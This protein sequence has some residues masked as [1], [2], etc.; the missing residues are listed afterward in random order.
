MKTLAANV[1]I[2][3]MLLLVLI[4]MACNDDPIAPNN[5][6][7]KPTIESPPNGGTG[8]SINPILRWK[9][10]DPDGDNLSYDVYFGTS[11]APPLQ[12]S[13]QSDTSYTP[14]TLEYGTEYNW[15]IVAKDDEGGST[16]SNI[17][18][19]TTI[20]PTGPTARFTADTTIAEDSLRV[21]F[22][23]QSIA[24]TSAIISWNWDFGDDNSSSL[25]NPSHLYNTIGAF[26]VSLTVNTA[27]GSDIETKSDYIVVNQQTGPEPDAPILY[28]PPDETTIQDQ[29]PT[30]VWSEPEYADG[31]H[32]KVDNDSLFYSAEINDTNLS[33]TTYTPSTGLDY[34]TYYWIVRAKNIENVWGDWSDTCSFTINEPPD[35]GEVIGYVYES[36]NGSIYN[37]LVKLY[38]SGGYTGKSDYTN[39]SGYFD[40]N[41][42]DPGSYY[43]MV[44]KSGYEPK[45]DPSS[46]Y[47]TV[48]PGETENRGTIYLTPEPDPPEC[49][50]S[51]TSLNF[52]NVNIDS[53]GDL[54]FTITNTGGG[55]LS[56]DPNETCSHYSIVSGGEPY[57]LGGGQSHDVTVRFSPTSSGTKTCTIETGNPI[58]SDVSCTGVSLDS[59][60][61]DFVF[62]TGG[63]FD[64]SG[65]YPNINEFEITISRVE[66]DDPAWSNCYTPGDTVHARFNPWLTFDSWLEI[67]RE[68]FSGIWVYSSTDY[69]WFTYT[70]DFKQ[71]G[72]HLT[73]MFGQDCESFYDGNTF[74]DDYTHIFNPSACGSGNYYHVELHVDSSNDEV[75][76][77]Q[78]HI[79]FQGW[80]ANY[81]SISYQ[82][83]INIINEE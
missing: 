37:A 10:S 66:L 17:W 13:S 44:S 3:L 4:L 59:V 30:F 33:D 74:C 42:V 28:Q 20:P 64:V 39:S 34:D 60:Y 54:D 73:F 14:G 83:K 80:Y 21:Q 56:G 68:G 65:N 15:K 50:V 36:G 25:Q 61:L 45:R 46:G 7:N 53:Y 69:V 70:A 77:S 19:F 72:D 41:N 35:P 52:G 26:T 47:F 57:N 8:Q 76:V 63:Y 24:G 81:G 79:Y 18:D 6:P 48:D 43:L 62:I 75:A 2:V 11:A 71:Q 51:E 23:D 40:I 29:T 55:T 82:N 67:Y 31:Y 1:L 12:S 32:L 58:C 38:D 16:S 27:V 9:C 22:T 5:P 49:S 78:L